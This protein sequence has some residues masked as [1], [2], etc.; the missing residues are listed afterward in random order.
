[1]TIAAMMLLAVAAPGMAQQVVDPNADTNVTDPAF[2]SG[3]GPVV[4]VDSGHDEFQTLAKNYAPFGAVLT[5]DGF[6]V[7]DFDKPIS[8]AN[9][10][11]AGMLVIVDPVNP[12]DPPDRPKYQSTSAFTPQE[13]ATIADWVKDGGALLMIADHPPYAGGLRALA[14]TFGFVIEI[15]AAQTDAKAEL[16]SFANGGLVDGPLTHG[17]PQIQTFYGTSFTAPAAATPLLRFDSS[18]KMLVTDKPPRPMTPHDLRGA[19]LSVGKGRVV[20]L[21][22]AGAWSAQLSGAKKRFMGFDA[23]GALGNK[24]F[25]RNVVYWLA[26]GAAPTVNAAK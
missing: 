2:A 26:T 12:N 25:I 6:V 21:A 14:S 3:T 11:G 10:A 16:F 20:L 9:L 5:H 15:Y 18:W 8:A 7:R 19:S 13:I 4:L 24:R 17:L 22:E 23:P 1:M